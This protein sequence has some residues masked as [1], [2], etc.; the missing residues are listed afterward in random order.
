[1][2]HHASSGQHRGGFF[3]SERGQTLIL[4]TFALT[5]LVGFTGL[6]ID[7]GMYMHER[8]DRQNASDAAALAGAAELPDSPDAAIDQARRFVLNN[9]FENSDIES[10]TVSSTHMANDT[11][12]VDLRS[13]FTWGF[14]RVFGLN[15][16]TVGAEAGAAIGSP[17][18]AKNLAPWAVLDGAID[19]SGG[20]TVLKY[21][22][23]DSHVGNFGP[24][25][26]DGTGAR[27]YEDTIME[28]SEVSLCASGQSGCS[29]PTAP[30]QTGNIV[31]STGDGVNYLI[32]NTSENCDSF[33]EVFR[34]R[35]DGAYNVVSGC[36][37]WQG[38][39]DSNRVILV[40]V[41]D[42]FCNGQCDVTVLYFAV[43]FLETLDRCTGN[44]CQ[45][46][47]RF[48]KVVTN[49]SLEIGSFDPNSAI[50]S[51]HLVS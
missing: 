17:S 18:A 35:S 13:D 22:S 36:N 26:I 12:T 50:T 14:F 20:P 28:G 37:P 46:T 34:Q 40:P 27:V 5:I 7:I 45:I 41:I 32:A 23:R 33:A 49:P 47:G 42:S 8:R 4:F 21:D 29:D 10:I 39:T 9:G 31:G 2:D 3:G 43:F 24:L 6:T 25:A 11:I 16:G 44:N 30:T 15:G 19:W 48:V 51:I 1:M 38:A